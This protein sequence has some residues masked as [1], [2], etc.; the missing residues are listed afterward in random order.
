MFGYV[1]ITIG[2]IG[3]ISMCKRIMK[4]QTSS[5]GDVPFFK[6]GTFGGKADSY[7][8]SDTY[9]KYKKAYSFPNK[10]DILISAAGTI[11]RTVRYDGEPAYFQD[12][13]IVWVAN[14]ETIVLN[15]YL[16]YVY[17]LQP[18]KAS[19]GGTIA[20]LYNENIS[21]AEIDVP[22]I[23]EQKRIVEVLRRFNSLCNSI[24]E[25]LPS[26]IE[27]RQKQYEY[28]RDK[29]LSFREKQ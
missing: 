23:Q 3:K 15:D 11:G 9:E 18:W 25:G 6:I 27:A 20:R 12:S 5:E 7:I 1:H 28:Y 2:D 19:T 21:K 17:Q 13:N 4:A 14:D 8:S 22:T 10:G 16:Y 24:S 29:L 26:E